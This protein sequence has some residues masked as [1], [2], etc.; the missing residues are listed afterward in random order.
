MQPNIAIEPIRL[1]MLRLDPSTACFT[2]TH[3][4]FADL[5]LRAKAFSAAL[6]ILENNIYYFPS[7]SGKWSHLPLPCSQHDISSTYITTATGL[8]D[9]LKY[10]DHLT[11][12]LY[13]AMIYM[14]LRNW[15]RASLFLEIVVT[16]PTGHTA[17]MIQV[18]AYKKWVL[19]SLLLTGRVR[20][21]FSSLQVCIFADNDLA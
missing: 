7:I 9:K 11:Y 13:G 14:G 17:S 21:R 5:C 1:A 6:P 15:D 10:Q 18:E 19:V 12:F 3:L 20:N 2:S 8:S 4:I 16:S